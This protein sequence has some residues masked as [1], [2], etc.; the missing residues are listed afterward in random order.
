[1]DVMF[2]TEI[3]SLLQTDP[4]AAAEKI[5]TFIERQNNTPLNIAITGET[6]SGKSTFI[7]YFQRM[8]NDDAGAAP[9]GVTETTIDVKEYPHPEYPNVKLWDFPGIGTTKFPADTYLE[10]LGSRKFDFFIIISDTRFRENDV[11]LAKAIQKMKKKFYFV[12]SKIDNDLQ[13]E[14]RGKRNVNE[15]EILQKIRNDCIQGLQDE[16]FESPQVFLLSSF[17]LHLYDFPLLHE[18]LERELPELMRHALLMT[19]PNINLEV[20]KKKKKALQAQIKYYAAGSAAGAAVPVPGLSFAVD[21][22][23]IVTAVTHFVVSFSLDI[24]SLKKLANTTGVPYDDLKKVILSP[25]AAVKITSELIMKVLSQLASVATLMAG[26][27]VSRWIPIIGIPATMAFSFA[28]TYKA[29][30]HI[31]N[32]LA[33]DAE[34]VFKRALGLNS[35]E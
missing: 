22:G 25:L 28:G 24:P 27:E 1:M 35:S 31:L 11:K 6:G 12:R 15:Q 2:D 8:T 26:E 5:N 13:A 19:I 14:A 33:E 23:I 9:T 18:T 7:N 10:L 4:A 21:I 29:L 30:S 32:M 3:K 17:D 34:R 16:G 20:I